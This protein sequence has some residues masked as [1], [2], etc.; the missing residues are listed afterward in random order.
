MGKN[1]STNYC[2]FCLILLQVHMTHFDDVHLYVDAN[3]NA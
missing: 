3:S 2:K 1:V